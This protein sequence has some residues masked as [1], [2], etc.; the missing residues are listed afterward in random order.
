L[1]YSHGESRVDPDHARDLRGRGARI[2]E[3]S[4]HP[5]CDIRIRRQA[6]IAGCQFSGQAF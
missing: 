6:N 2:L 1:Q 4:L 5:V 3:G